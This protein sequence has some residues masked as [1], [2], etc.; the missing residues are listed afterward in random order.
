MTLPD[1]PGRL[2]VAVAVCTRDRPAQLRRALRSLL[3]QRPPAGELL[4]V[5]NA[6]RDAATRELVGELEGVR[7]ALEPE[8]GLDRA[9]NRA[10]RETEAAVVAFLDDDAVA[11]PD[12]ARALT[13]AFD[14]PRVGA[15]TGRVEALALDTEAQRLFEANGGYARGTTG[16]RLPR[17]ARRPLHGRSAPLIAWTVSVGNGSSLAVRRDLALELGAFDE[18][19]DRGPALPGGGDL[20]VLWRVLAAGS[21]V[22]YEPAAL[23][24]HE[25]RQ[26]LDSMFDQLAGHQRALTAMLLK[27]ALH[28][29]RR[30]SLLAFLGWRLLKPGVRLALRALGRDP[31]PARALVRMWGS[32]WRGLG[33]YPLHR[34]RPAGAGRPA[35]PGSGASA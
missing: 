3:E 28:G 15:C 13:A 7:Y 35:P 29:P 17:D 16:I 26:D 1:A 23:A 19:L 32:C 10:L 30:A 2:R 34:L 6:P 9:R 21:D 25:H 24:W 5:D 31:L 4:V 33:S 12:W 27:N 20:D 18:A 11:H 14:D 22:V 8:P